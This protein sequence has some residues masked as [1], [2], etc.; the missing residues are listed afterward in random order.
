MNGTE[1]LQNNIRGINALSISE[2]TGV[3]RPTVIRKVKKLIQLKNIEMD[4][5]KLLHIKF[6]KKKILDE[7][8]QLQNETINDL[9]IFLA[10]TFNQI[11]LN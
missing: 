8:S 11:N 2:I 5:H 7:M 4:E 9:S 3:P 1:I 6:G 10:R